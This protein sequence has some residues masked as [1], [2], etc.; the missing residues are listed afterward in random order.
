[1]AEVNETMKTKKQRTLIVLFGFSVLGMSL[2]IVTCVFVH[3]FLAVTGIEET[4]ALAEACILKGL[5][6]QT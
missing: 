2:S 3:V 5:C 1:M 6:L 4:R